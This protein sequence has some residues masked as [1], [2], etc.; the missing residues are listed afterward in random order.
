MLLWVLMNPIV[1]AASFLGAIFVADQAPVQIGPPQPVVT[2]D[3]IKADREKF[4]RNYKLDTKRPWDGIYSTH[5]AT[6][7][8]EPLPKPK[9]QLGLPR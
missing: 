3:S 6:P 7:E 4:E 9:E 8:I 5:P 2:P 1:F